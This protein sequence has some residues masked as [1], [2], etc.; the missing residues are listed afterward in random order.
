MNAVPAFQSSG[1]S[2]GHLCRSASGA[3]C[4]RPLQSRPVPPGHDPHRHRARRQPIAQRPSHRVVLLSNRPGLRQLTSPFLPGL[5]DLQL[6][7]EPLVL[8]QSLQFR[9]AQV[10]FGSR[11]QNT[12]FMGA[13]VTAP[14]LFR[15]QD[16]GALSVSR[17]KCCIDR[18]VPGAGETGINP[19][20]PVMLQRFR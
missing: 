16:D 12:A 11:I 18:P 6:G 2:S 17:F 14:F 9:P 20:W 7:K 8:K 15:Q 10:L 13:P 3:R 5:I 1:I 4:C 19:K